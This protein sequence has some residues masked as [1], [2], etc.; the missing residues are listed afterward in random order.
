MKLVELF[1][2]RITGS[3]KSPKGRGNRFNRRD[4]END[5]GYPSFSDEFHDDEFLTREELMELPAKVLRGRCHRV[6]LDC[7]KLVEKRDL[8]LNLHDYYRQV[9]IRSSP[10]R[11]NKNPHPQQEAFSV[12]QNQQ[13]NPWN[14][15]HGYNTSSDETDQMHDLLEQVLPYFGQGDDAIDATVKDT[16]N[17]LP[18]H[19]LE[20]RNAE[21]NTILMMCCQFCAL[22]LIPILLSKGSSPNALNQYGESCL[23]FTCYS[24]S[25]SLEAAQVSKKVHCLFWIRKKL[26]HF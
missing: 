12:P 11:Y 15:S 20:N 24:D 22:E 6:G 19:C 9:L 8:V 4:I 2:K 13:L 18:F 25:F 1:T 5:G 17:R 23:H 26:F 21:G 10:S 16:I 14:S 3:G 7:S